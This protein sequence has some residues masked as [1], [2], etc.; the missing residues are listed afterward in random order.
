MTERKLETYGDMINMKLHER[1]HYPNMEVTRVIGG[2]IYALTN[3]VET[4]AES[5][6]TQHSSVWTTVFVPSGEY[7]A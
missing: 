5:R 3:D 4:Y 1:K 7:D 2:W 6:E